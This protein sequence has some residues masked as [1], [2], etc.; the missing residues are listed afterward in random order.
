LIVG[1]P[2]LTWVFLNSLLSHSIFICVRQ[3][4]PIF[5]RTRTEVRQSH[6]TPIGQGPA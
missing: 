4:H 2:K 1:Q 3:G 6:F 5:Q